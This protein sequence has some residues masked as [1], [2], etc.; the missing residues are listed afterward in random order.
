MAVE[1]VFIAA[2]FPFSEPSGI[3]SVKYIMFNEKKKYY[4]IICK[5]RNLK[6]LILRAYYYKKKKERKA[7]G[8]K[9]YFQT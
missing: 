6:T 7:T 5:N 3:F 8:L 1:M 9:K 4:K 2:T